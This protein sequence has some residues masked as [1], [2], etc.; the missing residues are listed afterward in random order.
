M[1]EVRGRPWRS[2]LE[3]LPDGRTTVSLRAERRSHAWGRVSVEW[4]ERRSWEMAGDEE[5]TVRASART[6][7]LKVRDVRGLPLSAS[8]VVCSE[9]VGGLVRGHA[10]GYEVGWARSTEGWGV[11]AGVAG[12]TREGGVALMRWTP[13]LPGEM[14]LGGWDSGVSWWV[15]GSA[16]WTRTLDV[17]I[18]AAGSGGEV[19]LGAALVSRGLF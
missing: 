8:V 3:P 10:T 5:S 11:D 17:M 18:R 15:R 14:G 6:W 19:S 7:R 2:Y 13:G 4:R 12:L 1:V 9:A 16:A